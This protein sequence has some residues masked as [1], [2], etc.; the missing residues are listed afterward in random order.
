[1][2]SVMGSGALPAPI[3]MGGRLTLRR[4]SKPAGRLFRLKASS[5][6]T[7]GQPGGG[8]SETQPHPAPVNASFSSPLLR[9][10]LYGGLEVW[11]QRAFIPFP[12][13]LQHL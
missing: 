9:A 3:R 10:P 6:D 8:E 13:L 7:G 11:L 4:T 2:Q 1:M 5:F 12:R